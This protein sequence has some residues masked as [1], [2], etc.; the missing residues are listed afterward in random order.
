MLIVNGIF[1]LMVSIGCL[2]WRNPRSQSMIEQWAANNGY[3]VSSIESR[4]VLRGPFFFTTSR[5]Q[6][7]H[8]VTFTAADGRAQPAWVRCGS[9]L[10]G[11]T[12]SDRV[13]VRWAD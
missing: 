3:R 12:F 2:F 6:T 8:Y 7:V 1:I 10:G 13:D 5:N 11:I 9:W 4:L